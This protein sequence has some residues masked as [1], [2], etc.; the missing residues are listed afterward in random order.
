M[1]M[2]K[3]GGDSIMLCWYFSETGTGGLAR[4]E[5]KLSPAKYRDIFNENLFHIPLL[6]VMLGASI[7]VSV[8]GVDLHHLNKGCPPRSMAFPPVVR[9][10]LNISGQVHNVANDIRKRSTSPWEYSLDIDQNRYPHVIAEAKCQHD[11]C[12]DSEGNVDFSMNS[13]PIRQ[14][15]LV[16]RRELRG[17]NYNFK[18]AKKI[19]T[20]G[21]TCVRPIIQHIM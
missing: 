15:M 11:G 13:I 3:H 2:V 6:L 21:C 20:V 16:L 10:S 19:V 17:C 18:L 1:P 5:E 12:L 8:H 14:E 7:I 4:V 9:V